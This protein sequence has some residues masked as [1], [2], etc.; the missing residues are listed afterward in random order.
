MQKWRP[1]GRF[2][3]AKSRHNECNVFLSPYLPY[4]TLNRAPSNSRPRNRNHEQRLQN[5]DQLKVLKWLAPPEVR[6]PSKEA[7]PGTNGWFLEGDLFRDWLTGEK[8]YVFVHGTVGCGK[9]TLL[10][11]A[12]KSCRQKV[13]ESTNRPGTFVITFFFSSIRNPFSGLNDLLRHLI[14]QLSPLDSIPDALYEI[15]RASTKT[16]PHKP[17]NDDEELVGV[18]SKILAGS[19]PSGAILAP[20]TYIFLDGLDEIATLPECRKVTKFLNKLAALNL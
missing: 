7:E 10:E 17:P 14:A 18:L 13:R 20:Q 15:Y 4:Q 19:S 12:A 2:H 11:S 3:R 9:T 5:K 1:L 8:Q 6:P 16:F